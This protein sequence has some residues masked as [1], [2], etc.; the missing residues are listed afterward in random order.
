MT[1][2]IRGCDYSYDRPGGALLAAAGMGFVVRYL[3]PVV[4]GGKGLSRPEI[5][6]LRRHGIEIVLVHE[7]A[8]DAA[9]EGRRRGVEDARAA[10]D[11]LERLDLDPALPIYFA[12]DFDAT[13][14]DQ[15]AVDA[16]LA[17][18]ASVVG[19]SRT[20]V[21]GGH[22]VITR[23]RAAGSASWFW[24]THAWSHGEVAE[25]I[26]LYQHRIEDRLDGNAVDLDLAL[27]PEYGQHAVPPAAGAS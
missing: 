15:D 5:D 19:P 22:G 18:A 23:C 24:Q 3:S 12:V 9:A 11:H 14:A 8:P 20:G 1:V 7:E 16:Y 4:D 21:Y 25:D 13:A 10:Q 17:G 6:D 27:K 26:H 2:S